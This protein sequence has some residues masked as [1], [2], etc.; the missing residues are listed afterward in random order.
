MRASG[1]EHLAV[2]RASGDVEGEE[3]NV[4]ADV[5]HLEAGVGEGEV[6]SG[7]GDMSG[8]QGGS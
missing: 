4:G 2:R 7:R 3:A 6:M 5:D 1:G 8:T